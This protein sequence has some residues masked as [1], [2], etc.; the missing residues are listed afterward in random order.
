[1]VHDTTGSGQGCNMFRQISGLVF[2]L[3]LVV[4]VIAGFAIHP[5]EAVSARAE[6]E[7]EPKAGEVRKFEIAKGVEME[8]CWIPSGEAQLGSPKAEQD[9]LAKDLQARKIR[10]NGIAQH[11]NSETEALRGKFKSKG[12]WLG[13]YVVTQAEWKAVMGDNPSKFDGIKDNKAKGMV[14]DRFPVEEVS[15]NDCQKFLDRVNDRG[16]AAK[17]FGKTGKF[18]LPHE[19]EWE[20]ACRGGKGNKQAFYFGDELNGT[21]ANC[22]GST[23]FGTATKGDSKQRTT[24]VGSYAKDWPHPWGLCDMHGNVYQWCDNLYELDKDQSRVVR[25]G[26]WRNVASSC[27]SAN[28]GR[29][30]LIGSHQI[31]IGLRVCFRLD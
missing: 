5:L 11:L 27:R 13:K 3:L 25:G 18:V 14:T 6:P 15:W 16:G 22:D 2:P 26:S 1:M 8:F 21:Q 10:E 12:F 29:F 7:K 23:P 31:S 28:R 9:A 24:E 19:D 17:A 30:L 4:T 20:Y